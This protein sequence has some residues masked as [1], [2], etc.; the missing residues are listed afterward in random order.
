MKD[1]NGKEIVSAKSKGG[2]IAV[3]HPLD[4]LIQPKC[5]PWPTPEILQKLYQSRQVR[6]FQNE[7]L[8][9]CKS[10]IGYYC[11]LQS[12]HSEDAIT[13]SVFGTLA[14]SSPDDK[15]SW[16]ADFFSLLRIP[17]ASPSN[18]EIYLWRRLPHPDTL[19]SGGPEIDFGIITD[20]SVVLG[21]AKWQSGIGFAQGKKKDKDQIQ[22]R[23]EFLKKYGSRIFP[24]LPIKA[25]VGVSL[26]EGAL[27]GFVPEGIA[28]FC[29]TWEKI[30]SIQS[31]PLFDEVRRYYI[32][33]KEHTKG[34]TK[35]WS[36]R[37][38][39]RDFSEM[40]E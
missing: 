40:P 14:R 33:K 10:G 28:L 15:E 16:T 2:V 34:P 32:W 19:V 11:D 5:T 21:E 3:S 24:D 22:L 27:T 1:W 6:A 17:G 18:A 39:N 12:I 23:G 35:G 31:H 36:R 26:Y 20:N 37:Q 30:C 8:S 4:N 9:I 29:T 13:W 38:E 25:V 7:Q